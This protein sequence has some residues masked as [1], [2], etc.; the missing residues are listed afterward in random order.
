MLMAPPSGYN[1]SPMNRQANSLLGGVGAGSRA[2]PVL[3]NQLGSGFSSGM[4]AL[5]T[6]P[7]AQNQNLAMILKMLKG[8]K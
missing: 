6:N 7:L 8:G 5:S 1:A 2:S 4:P 3:G